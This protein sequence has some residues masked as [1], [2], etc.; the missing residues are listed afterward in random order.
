ME[1]FLDGLCESYNLV[2]N[3]PSLFKASL[4]IGKERIN[5]GIY[6]THQQAF[7][8]LVGEERMSQICQVQEG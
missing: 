2:N 6:S 3:G 1:S 7:Y 8:Q 5:D 4:V